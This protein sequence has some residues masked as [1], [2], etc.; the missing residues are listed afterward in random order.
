MDFSFGIITDGSSDHNISLMIDSIER[1]NIPN[2]E[3]II[4]GNSAI[5]RKNTTVVP[6][7]EEVLQMWITHKKN[8]ITKNAKYENI[9]YL[10]DY[11]IFNEYWYQGFLIHGNDFN[12]CM[13]KIINLDGSRFRDWVL[14]P[15]NNN[16]MDALTHPS[17][18]CLI[19]YEVRNLSKYMYISGSY[20]VAKKTLMEEFPLDESL[21]W[22]QGEDVEWSFRV[23]DKFDFSMN[24]LSSV[25]LLKYK[26]AVF[27]PPDENTLEL[28]KKFGNDTEELEVL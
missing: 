9:V 14:W 26:P 17:L 28:L 25:H 12:V 19:P 2:Y 8:L 6:F 10:H 16:D 15:H 23:R 5:S 13:T 27:Y 18:Q 7:A 3:I 1:M 11:I 22:G 4:I 21:V 24:E 20:W